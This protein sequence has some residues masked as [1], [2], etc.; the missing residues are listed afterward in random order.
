[1]FSLLKRNSKHALR[2]KWGTAILVLLIPTL[3]GVALSFLLG[4]SMLV[5]ELIDSYEGMLYGNVSPAELSRIFGSVALNNL[6]L[7]LINLFLLSPIQLG[8][9]YWFFR[10]VKG[11]SQPFGSLFRFFENFGRYKR[12]VWFNFSLS[13]RQ[14]LWSLLFFSVP[15]IIF[16]VVFALMGA[17][18]TP[19][20]INYSVAIG[21]TAAIMVLC[22]LVLAILFAAYMNKYFL[23]AY[24]ICEDDE[25]KVSEAIKTSIQYTKGY[26]FS[27]IGFSLT[28]FGWL[29]LSMIFFPVLF[30]VQPYMTT[31]FAMYAQYILET[32]HRE[33]PSLMDGPPSMDNPMPNVPNNGYPT[34]QSNPDDPLERL[35]DV[36]GTDAG[37]NLDLDETPDD[38]Y[39]GPELR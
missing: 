32:K 20:E 23:A 14:G 15:G 38:N 6:I 19:G 9:T 24:L 7:F 33:N 4:T 17:F 11:D 8:V 10:L 3:I 31:S 35:D 18:S 13:I 5:R 27:L 2:N 39:N 26:R 36:W 37:M 12:S 21:M 34:I 29:L 1:M 22:F 25:I 28:F 16:G 30:Y